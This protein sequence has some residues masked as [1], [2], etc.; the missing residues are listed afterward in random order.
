M[1]QFFGIEL[2]EFPARIAETA[3]WMMDH[4][5]NN[6]LSLA[7]GQNYARIP[8]DKA[9]NIRHGDALDIDWHDVLPAKACSYVFGNPPFI[10]HQWR[11]KEQQA[12]MHKVWGQKGQ[13]NRL[14]Y[15]TCWFKL[16]SV[17]SKGHDNIQ[18]AFVATN[19]IAQGEQASI[20]WPALLDL[21]L[22]HI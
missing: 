1:D 5:M 6:E 17:Y 16:A 18:T 20:L 3:M 11:S 4:I 10:G 14:D 21:S 22:I 7:F 9:A 12:Q 19:S 13:V 2:E 15:V 8:L